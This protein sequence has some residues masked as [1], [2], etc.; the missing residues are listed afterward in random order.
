MT[1]QFTHAR[2]SADKYERPLAYTK[3]KPPRPARIT[4]KQEKITS[5]RGRDATSGRLEAGSRVAP[6]VARDHRGA[7]N[8]LHAPGDTDELPRVGPFHP[9]R[10]A[11]RTSGRGTVTPRKLRPVTARSE[12]RRVGTGRTAGGGAGGGE[13][14]WRS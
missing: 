1:W 6:D 11:S 3:V 12:E 10:E 5:R 8:P 2:G 7:A 9:E 4:S 13:S 14:V